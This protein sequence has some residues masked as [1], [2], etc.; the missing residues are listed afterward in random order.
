VTGAAWALISPAGELTWRSLADT[1]EVEAIVSGDYA[2][3]ALASASV[4][5]PLR[6]MASDIALVAPDHYLPNPVAVR[7]ITTLSGGRILQPWRG[8]VALVQ[9]EQDAAT[10]EWLWPG[11]MSPAWAELIAGAVGAAGGTEAPR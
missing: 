7:V 2:P 8:H 10:G 4:T 9:Y 1:P 5:G 11:E 6:V 3:G